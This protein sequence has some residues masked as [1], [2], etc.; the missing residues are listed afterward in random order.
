[1]ALCALLAACGGHHST[2]D[3]TTGD[4]ASIVVSPA[5]AT[6]SVPIGQTATQAYTIEGVADDGT[7]TDITTSCALG[8]PS[9]F[10]AV[11]GQSV[12]VN[13]HGGKTTVTATCGALAGQ[14]SLIVQVTGQ[15]VVDPA[16]ANAPM[17]FGSATPGAGTAPTIEYPLDKAVAPRN[18]PTI[19]TQWAGNGSDLFHVNYASTF[20]SID[21]YTVDAKALLDESA[22]L[23]VI[24]SAAG[25]QLAITVEGLA[26]AAPQTKT[27]ASVSIKISNDSIDT[28]AIYYWASSQGNIMEQ[29]FGTTTAPDLVKDGCT[30]CHSVSRT[31]SRIGYSRCVAGDCGQLFGGF[32]HFN[33]MSGAW[34]EAVNANDKKLQFSYS[35]FAPLGNPFPDDSQALAIVSMVDGTLALVDPDTGANVPSNIS[36]AASPNALMADWSPDGKS[37][38]FTASPHAGQWI[39]LADGTISIMSYAYTGGAHTFGTPTTLVPNPQTLPNGTY[40]NF[41]FPSFSPDGKYVVFDAARTGWR[42]GASAKG[43][44]SRLMLTDATGAWVRD[45]TAMNGGDVDYDITW[46]HWAPGDSSEYLW[47]VFSSERDYGHELTSANTNPAC[48]NVGVTQCKQI[49]IGAV[50]KNHLDGSVDPSAPPMWLPGQDIQA[51][52]I[53]PYW[54]VPSGIQ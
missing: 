12:V 53:S 30:S 43:A 2:G 19:E 37:V 54:S 35:T 16:P 28:S 10:G 38:V 33:P 13:P 46:S 26:Q 42:N 23:A 40:T 24:G 41:F 17:L 48:N 9:P 7:H 31:A 52:N 47:L 4:Y 27:S 18:M 45:L 21:L 6:L 22:W 1:M 36:V 14:A 51:D 11:S 29:T 39:D 25:D 5:Q 20:S 50:A 44:G 3:D 15:I 34:D 49:W 8:I 32:L